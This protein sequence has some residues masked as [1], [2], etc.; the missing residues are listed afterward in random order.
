MILLTTLL[1][2]SSMPSLSVWELFSFD[3]FAHAFLFG[4][5]TFLMIVG[6]TKQF[7]YLKLRHFAIRASLFISF[8]FGVFVELM[9][10]FFIYG[11]QGDIMDVLANTIGCL[12]GIVLFKWVYIW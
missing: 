9:Q 8:M 7:S 6:L 4:I 11:R 3:S 10:H 2:S 5:L 12:L 1:P